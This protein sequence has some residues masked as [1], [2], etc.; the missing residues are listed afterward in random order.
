MAKQ[1]SMTPDAIKKREK[2]AADKQAQA[3]EQN[4]PVVDQSDAGSPAEVAPDSVH[5]P[6]AK[7]V[8][9]TSVC[10]VGHA[11]IKGKGKNDKPK[12]DSIWGVMHVGDQYV[13]F[14]G[15]VGGALRFKVADCLEEAKDLYAQKLDGT[16]A[17]K[18]KHVDLAPSKQVELLG[19]DWPDSLFARYTEA[20]E[21]GAVDARKPEHVQVQPEPAAW[22]W[23]RSAA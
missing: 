13:K 7:P 9:G 15:R 8:G 4:V 18:L 1:L 12:K 20:L 16:D 19:N 3:V 11:F 21:R 14:F 6:E 10:F 23:P 2:R 5:V 22:P 17:K